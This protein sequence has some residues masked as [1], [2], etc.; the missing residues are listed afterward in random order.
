M[1]NTWREIWPTSSSSRFSDGWMNKS[2]TTIA[3]E[4]RRQG[5]QV[6]HETVRQRLE[7]LD[8]SLQ[9]NRK[10]KEGLSPPQRDEQF[11][12]IN[13]QVKRFFAK[14][15]PVISVDTKKKE[16]VGNFK[17]QGKTW[18]P[19]GKPKEV[20]SKDFPNLGHGTAVP[21]GAY[22]LERNEGFVNVG[23]S[24]DTAEFAVESL[25]RWWRLAGRRNYPNAKALLICAD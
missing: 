20:L 4:L 1:S 2:T 10:N 18:R 17:N 24:H 16:K 19:K 7:E 11:R 14:G 6:S 23:M 25:R 12:Y 9:A 13:K 22:D 21:Y 15:E 8:Y 3:E 5:H